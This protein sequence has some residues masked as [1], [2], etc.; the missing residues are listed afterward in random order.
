M[1]LKRRSRSRTVKVVQQQP[2]STRSAELAAGAGRAPVLST[3]PTANVGSAS[4]VASASRSTNTC[5]ATG[6]GAGTAAL[7]TRL[8]FRSTH[9]SSLGLVAV[10]NI[11]E[12]KASRFMWQPE[13]EEERERTAI[14][15]TLYPKARLVASG[16]TPQPP[17]APPLSP[18]S[19]SSS[20]SSPSSSAYPDL[21]ETSTLR[22]LA[23]SLAARPR[24]VLAQD[25]TAAYLSSTLPGR[26]A[27]RRRSTW[28]REI[29]FA[30]KQ[31]VED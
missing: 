18:S 3:A 20:S 26:V 16:F 10:T 24:G 4:G 29:Y 22:A 11:E 31:I 27:A 19:S 17:T 1:K 21:E 6:V 13:E 5:T 23:A 25:L 14:R 8:I 12:A 7:A 30:W 28:R 2:I 15:A 9:R